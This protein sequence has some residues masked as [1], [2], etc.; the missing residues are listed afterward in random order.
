MV[1]DE[2][3]VGRVRVHAL[4]SDVQ[5]APVVVEDAL[6]VV[7]PE[8]VGRLLQGLR[9]DALE[10]HHAAGLDVDVGLA[11]DLDLRDCKA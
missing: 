1:D 5:D 7:V 6:V 10:R 3:A 4:H 11:L 2:R 9:D 8:N